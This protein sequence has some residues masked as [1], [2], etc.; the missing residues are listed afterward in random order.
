MKNGNYE[1]KLLY[2]G[3]L[4]PTCGPKSCTKVPIARLNDEDRVVEEYVYGSRVNVPE[5]MIK[6]GRKYRF[7][8]DHRGSVRMVVD[9][10]NGTVMQ[11][12]DY[13]EFGLIIDEDLAENWTPVLF[14]YAGGLQDRDT[15]LI[16][17]GA[18]D[19]DP[20]VGRWTSK[21]PLGFNGSSN[22]YVYAGNDPVNFVDPD[23]NFAWIAV[24]VL[25]LIDFFIF[26]RLY[27]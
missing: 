6:D 25:I 10:H 16:R 1:Y 26:L 15:G 20:M 23:G 12:T 24:P 9:T 4:S 18:R 8:T 7:I 21:E 14:G 27:F 13:D 17:F 22:F 19:Y 11:R 2:S 5:Y 3:Q